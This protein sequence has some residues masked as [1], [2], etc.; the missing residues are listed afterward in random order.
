MSWTVVARKDFRDA[1][2]AKT[3]WAVTA[4]FALLTAGVAYL[5]TV[6]GGGEIGATEYV[7]F[8]P[9]VVVLFLSL[10]ALMV[11]HRSIIGER[12]S[13]TA[14]LLLSLPHSRRDVVLGKVA[15][16]G[17]VVGVATVLAFALTALVLL[18]AYSEFA[19]GTYLAFVALTL[20][21]AL[22]FTA[23]A[24][25]LSAALDTSAKVSAATYGLY[26]VFALNIWNFLPNA[27]NYLLNGE[28]FFGPEQPEWA[29]FLT[30]LSP[31]VAYERAVGG[32]A[33]GGLGDV[34]L[35]LSA[36]AALAVLILWI[37]GPLVLGYWRFTRAEI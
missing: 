15:G 6:L 5:L 37:V 19:A 8:L 25:G 36:W 1:V 35:F 18:V 11:G 2:R 33:L 24:V 20:T 9:Q 4:V 28:L 22:A 34:P 17:A 31:T 16:R 13:G 23:V 32:I 10:V 12:E 26:V 7:G 29:T 21:F 14:K 3:L 30:S 27:V